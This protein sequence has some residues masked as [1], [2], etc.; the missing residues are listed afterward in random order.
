MPVTIKYV[1]EYKVKITLDHLD[2]MG[3]LNNALYLKLLEDARW[4]IY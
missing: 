2:F 4:D 1:S 3:H